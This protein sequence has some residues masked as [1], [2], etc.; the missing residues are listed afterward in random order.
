M[1]AVA[2]CRSKVI[3]FFVPYGHL[4]NWLPVIVMPVTKNLLVCNGHVLGSKLRNH[5]NVGEVNTA[6]IRSSIIQSFLLAHNKFH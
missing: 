4:H 2:W 1:W 3:F 6:T 5:G